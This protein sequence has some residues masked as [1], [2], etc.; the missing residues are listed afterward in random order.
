M[1]TLY[2]DEGKASY[3]PHMVLEEIA[4]EYELV[5]IN[6]A[7]DK[8]RDPAFLK[9]NPNGWIPVLVHGDMVMHESAAIIMYLCDRHPE[10]GLAPPPDD[11]LR[12][13]FYQW[14]LYFSDTL[15]I[16][17]QMTYY[18]ERHS[19]DP[20]HVPAVIAKARERLDRV[21]GYIDDSLGAGP[22]FL[23]DRFSACDLYAYMLATW[24]PEGDE[25]FLA[26]VPNVARL[27]EDVTQ[28]SAVRRAMAVHI[29]T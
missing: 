11:A 18:P 26:T 22:Y 21:W 12:G 7:K 19:T 15:Q 27:V 13:H 24:H 14:L 29:V 3:A 5:R 6:V 25:A 28:R 23:G 8:P 17:Y 9:L 1:Y 10:A 16:A 20:A 4:A 2:Y